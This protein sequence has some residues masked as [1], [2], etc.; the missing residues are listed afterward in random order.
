MVTRPTS[1]GKM[2]TSAA[3]KT[4]ND[5]IA[6]RRYNYMPAS[7][8][9]IT[10]G[11][12]IGIRYE[13]NSEYTAVSRP[14]YAEFRLPD[15][16][17]YMFTSLLKFYERNF[18]LK[19][20]EVLDMDLFN[21]KSLLTEYGFNLA[22]V[23]SSAVPKK[24]LHDDWDAER[25]DDW[26]L[27]VSDSGGFQLISGTEEFL[28][29]VE[30]ITAHNAACDIGIVLDIPLPWM[31]QKDLLPKAAK[32]QKRNSEVLLKHKR[33]SL[34]LLNVFHGSTFYLREK[35]R[36]LVEDNR[37]PRC[38]IGGLRTAEL[39]PLALQTLFVIMNGKKY[40]QYHV[41]GVSHLERWV[42]LNYI[43][44]KKLCPLITSDSSSYIQA[45]V[46][47]SYFEP[48]KMLGILS[49]GELA[50]TINSHRTLG[51]GC[52]VCETVK[53]IKPM[54]D[55][56]SSF[57]FRGVV[58]HNLWQT[59]QYLNE[60]YELGAQPKVEI[61][62]YLQTFV[63]PLRL[64]NIRMALNAVDL[65]IDKGC[66]KAAAQYAPELLEKFVGDK[67]TKGLFGVLPEAGK[68]KGKFQ[69]F[70]DILAKYEKYH[71]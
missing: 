47:M 45:G 20:D 48:M 44:H 32:L 22:M 34:D 13:K 53:Y 17:L 28:D 2:T 66:E 54:G 21:N 10:K 55:R 70:Q 43:G 35:Y 65:A 29:P 11:M 8:D 68:H 9:T 4:T 59:A 33:P 56:R 60:L 37:M 16:T 57:G 5:R 69:R 23:N 67:S 46:N 24:Y 31:F 50:A 1:P 25:K 19:L 18:N 26:P 58:T 52:P 27:I 71:A 12:T 49:I 64:R 15:R 38:A 61:L 36:E 63:A 30:I 42:I 14:N 7:V 39:I 41:L 51:C 3:Y 6:Q 62:K 40:K